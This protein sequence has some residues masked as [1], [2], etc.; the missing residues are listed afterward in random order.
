MNSVHMFFH[1]WLEVVENST[2][3]QNI[4]QNS[5]YKCELYI[6]TAHF[7]IENRLCSSAQQSVYCCVLL[8]FHFG[9]ATWI[10][11]YC[12]VAISSFNA[13]HFNSMKMQRSA[14]LLF[15]FGRICIIMICG[16]KCTQHKKWRSISWTAGKNVLPTISRGTNGFIFG[17]FFI[18]ISFCIPVSKDR[19]KCWLQRRDINE[20]QLTP[21]FMHKL[22][23]WKKVFISFSFFFYC[24]WNETKQNEMKWNTCI[25]CSIRAM[26][27]KKPVSTT[28][29]CSKHFIYL[30]RSNVGF[31][32]SKSFFVH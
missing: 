21:F 29:D 12:I 30:M 19:Y 14:N 25:H 3:T 31:L 24:R 23:R 27:N 17:H 7:H 11:K 5:L 4:D 10:A 13:I 16:L 6:L 1:T 22:V 15:L 32:N 28:F 18:W 2:R 8:F 9:V 26:R 20:T